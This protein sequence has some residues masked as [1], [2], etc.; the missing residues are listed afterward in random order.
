M[1]KIL[2]LFILSLFVLSGCSQQ[3]N[4]HP[5][6]NPKKISMEQKEISSNLKLQDNVYV[7]FA[8][9]N[10]YKSK[11]KVYNEK[12][13][14]E[15]NYNQISNT[16]MLKLY[17]DK[18][19]ENELRYTDSDIHLS[20]PLNDI[21]TEINDNN[22]DKI[23]VY[24]QTTYKNGKIVYIKQNSNIDIEQNCIIFRPKIAGIYCVG[25]QN[26]KYKAIKTEEEIIDE[27]NQYNSEYKTNINNDTF[28]M[29]LDG[30][31]TVEIY[32]E[33]NELIKTISNN[34]I[35]KMITVND[36]NCLITLG[37][38][39]NNSFNKNNIIV[40]SC[41]DLNYK[42]KVIPKG[43]VDVTLVKQQY[44]NIKTDS[45][46]ITKWD[47]SHPNDDKLQILKTLSINNEYI[48]DK[49]S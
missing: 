21:I 18:N 22:I 6:N 41:I 15:C 12:D 23:C 36:N 47:L 33:S 4:N 32:D 2:Y 5:K 16:Y 7:L 28:C 46:D 25:I 9:T 34:N 3:N 14:T 1:K 44:D 48:L 26:K 17:N 42:Y 31:A 38:L 43:T 45:T 30:E 20:I 13:K 49:E 40:Q 35:K 11:I 37:E 39:N 29:V 24:R 19:A 8:K 10:D 27:T